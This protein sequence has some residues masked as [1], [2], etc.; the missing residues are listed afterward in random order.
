MTS[1]LITPMLF[2]SLGFILPP[3]VEAQYGSSC[4]EYGFMAYESGGYCKCMSGYVMGEDFMGNSQ[5]ISADQACKDQY[6]YNAKS[7]YSGGCECSYGYV[8][9]TGYSGDKQC[10][11]GNTV[12]SDKYGYGSEYDDLSGSCECRYGY[13]FGEDSIGRTQCIT[14]DQSCQ[15]ELGLH[16]SASFGGDC[17]CS[18]G[19]VIDSGQC[20]DAET[21][22]SNKHGIHSSYDSISNKCECDSEY[23]FDDNSQCVEKQHN[24]YFKL[25]DIKDDEK[26]I[27]VKSEYDSRKYIIEYGVGCFDFTIEQYLNKNLVINLG[28]DY[29]VDTWDTIVLQDNSQTCSIVHKERTYDDSF[30][31]PEVE[32]ESFNYYIPPVV[33]QT[34]TIQAEPKPVIKTS[35]LKEEIPLTITEGVGKEETTENPTSSPTTTVSDGTTESFGDKSQTT[36]PSEPRESILKR[37]L[38]FFINLF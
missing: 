15:N 1:L 7:N 34:P 6:G 29:E 25:L 33:S 27:L 23:T 19:Y 35:S 37:I 22:C 3:E 10:V 17:K 31:E 28:T 36:L 12:C 38:N 16:S 13:V 21:V 20:K 9:G 8:F 2:F 5:C 24:V 26:T 32:E 4:S 30:P 14:D 11:S 18:Y